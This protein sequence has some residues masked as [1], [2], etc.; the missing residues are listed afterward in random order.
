MKKSEIVSCSRRTDIPAFRMEWVVNKIKDGYVDVVNPFNKNQITRVSL[1]SENV[2]CWVWW[3]KNFAEWIKY[4]IRYKD[5]F[6]NFKGH[7][8]QFTINSPSELEPNL[9]ISLQERIEQLNWLVKEFGSLAVNYRF[10]PIIFYRKSN[11]KRIKNNLDKFEF[12][13]SEVSKMGI[14]EVIFS[15]ATMYSK[16]KRRMHARGYKLIDPSLKKKKQIIDKLLNICNK[17]NIKMKACCQ[18]DLLIIPGIE[19]SHCIDAYKIEKIIE[20]NIKKLK[21]TGQ[22]DSCGCYKS[23]DIGGYDGI[24]QCKHNCSY[25]YANPTRE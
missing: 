3:S 6:R 22:R 4:Y 2:K 14:D 16:V 23:K 1:S 12:I 8:F 7:Y 5:L 20:E 19:Q 15:F 18:P 17:F 13:I 24:F 11:S 9:N 25:C 10:D 21:D